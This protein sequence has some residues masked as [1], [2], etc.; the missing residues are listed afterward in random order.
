VWANTTGSVA[1]TSGVAVKLWQDSSVNARD[2][3]TAVGQLA[4]RPVGI[5]SNPAIDFDGNG[6]YFTLTGSSVPT[7]NA[8]YIMR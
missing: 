2:T 1:I 7:A 5:N 3:V 4:Y 8:T 6:D